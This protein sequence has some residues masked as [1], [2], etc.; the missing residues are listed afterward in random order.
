MSIILYKYT[1]YMY[2]YIALINKNV[3]AVPKLTKVYFYSTREIKPMKCLVIKH[4][5]FRI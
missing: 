5:V 2:L 4:F 3:C 1:I